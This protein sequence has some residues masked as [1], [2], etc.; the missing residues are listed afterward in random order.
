ML[1]EVN[2]K[3]K[4]YVHLDLRPDVWVMLLKPKAVNHD[5]FKL[6]EINQSISIDISFSKH[7]FHFF[8]SEFFTKIVHSY[9]DLLGR[10]ETITILIKYFKCL[11]DIINFVNFF[12]PNHHLYELIIVNSTIAILINISNHSTEFLRGGIEPM[13]VHDLSKFLSSYLPIIVGIK[14]GE[15]ISEALRVLPGNLH[16]WDGGHG[17]LL[18]GPLSLVEVNQAIL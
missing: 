9:S 6:C 3:K 5:P 2:V 16:Q 1:A 13:V 11:S 10:Y 7:C 15:S 18:E 4:N 12:P 17:E 14:Q 8:F